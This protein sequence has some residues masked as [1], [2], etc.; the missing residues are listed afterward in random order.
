MSI[1][2]FNRAS[3]PDAIADLAWHELAGLAIA[4]VRG[5]DAELSLPGPQVSDSGISA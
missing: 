3:P 1:W 5:A 4:V 2:M